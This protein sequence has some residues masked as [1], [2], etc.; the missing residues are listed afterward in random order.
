MKAYLRVF[1]NLEQNDLAKLLFIAEFAY[2]NTK[3]TNIGHI[4]LEHNGGYHLYVFFE[5]K[6]DPYSNTCLIKKVAKK[7]TDLMFIC[8]SFRNEFITKV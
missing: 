4:N 1:V 2:Y 7:L 8:K 3:N 6:T 5:N